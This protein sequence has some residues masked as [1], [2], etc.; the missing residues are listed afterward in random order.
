MGS[1]LEKNIMAP[2][3]ADLSEYFD[4]ELSEADRQ[5]VE[6][7]LASDPEYAREYERLERTHT[8]LALAIERPVFHARLMNRI[9]ARCTDAGTNRTG[10]HR[11]LAAAL[12]AAMVMVVASMV[13]LSLAWTA[14]EDRLPP[15]PGNLAAAP[16]PAE[17]QDS[18]DSEPMFLAEAPEPSPSESLAS[19]PIDTTLLPFTLVGTVT[20]SAPTAII[21]VNGDGGAKSGT[22][23]PG[24]TIAEGVTLVSVESGQVALDYHGQ[25]VV[26]TSSEAPAV[27][28]ANLSGEW[29]LTLLHNGNPRG[30]S[31]SVIVTQEGSRLT[32]TM[33][34]NLVRGTVAG[35]T[36]QARVTPDAGEAFA[37]AGVLNQDWTECTGPLP[38][39]AMGYA[40]DEE[41]TFRMTRV[42]ADQAESERLFKDRLNEV[43]EMARILKVYATRND[44]AYP[45][46]LE[47]LVPACAPNLDAFADTDVRKVQYTCIPPVKPLKMEDYPTY[48]DTDPSLPLPDRLMQWEQRLK[49]AGL[50]NVVFVK[51]GLLVDYT[52][53]EAR[54]RVTRSG[55]AAVNN[56]TPAVLAEM[57][58][59]CANNLKQLGLVVKMFENEHDGYTPGGW[60]SCYPEYLSDSSVLTSPKD[61]PGTDSYLYLL[62]ATNVEAYASEAFPDLV[63]DGNPAGMAKA[64]SE[65]PLATNRT[66]FPGETPVRNVLFADGHVEYMTTATWREKVLPYVQ[67][68]GN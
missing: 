3:L 32:A 7:R 46:K 12:A 6:L 61:E 25:N 22:Y 4:G 42:P 37:L 53:P 49:T 52:D 62:P 20:G 10:G 9:D 59:S 29:T 38:P 47:D 55:V 41:V 54:F 60:L 19:T 1:T 35:N 16:G 26:L 68:P 58:A 48:E 11:F 66:D 28:A 43:K 5:A 57:R 14:P 18:D 44:G 17:P 2:N 39:D 50:G 21:A 13:Y 45:P 33:A 30:Q 63:T 34:E 27:P 8:M 67:R 64:M 24:D 23:A 40:E 65:I 56:P 36:V 31:E 15:G 51:A